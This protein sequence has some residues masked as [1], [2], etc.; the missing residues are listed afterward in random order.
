VSNG[1]FT[2]DAGDVTQS[3]HSRLRVLRDAYADVPPPA[4]RGV[5]EV[6]IPGSPHIRRLTWTV[7]KQ[8][9]SGI[10]ESWTGRF[11]RRCPRKSGAGWSLGLGGGPTIAMK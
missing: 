1:A 10:V 4:S 7:S 11:S 9:I 6:V 3:S 2:A 5:V 8:A